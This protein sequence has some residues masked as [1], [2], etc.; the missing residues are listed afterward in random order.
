L[1]N[2]SH[3]RSLDRAFLLKKYFDDIMQ[4]DFKI[5]KKIYSA[6]QK[7]AGRHPP[8]FGGLRVK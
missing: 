2:N 7:P 5:N 3:T 6:A 1:K 8:A 4:E